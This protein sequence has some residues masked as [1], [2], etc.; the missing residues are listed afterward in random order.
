MPRR[1]YPTSRV[2][3]A[4]QALLSPAPSF[5]TDAIAA[6]L[7][8]E[9]FRQDKLTVLAGKLPALDSTDE[10]AVTEPMAKA[11]G[12]HPGSHMTWQFYRL[13]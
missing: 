10:I 13:S 7:G 1:D 5:Q 2:L 4:S 3:A 6:S 9:Y 11:F 12:L 8:G